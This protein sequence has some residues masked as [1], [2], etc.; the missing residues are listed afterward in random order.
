MERMRC[1]GSLSNPSF[2]V[3]YLVRRRIAHVV[4]GADIFEVNGVARGRSPQWLDGQ[5]S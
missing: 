5:A 1:L 4:R 2:F 3:L